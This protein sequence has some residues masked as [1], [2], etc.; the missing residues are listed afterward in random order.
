ME[1]NRV[2]PTHTTSAA[3]LTVRDILTVRDMGVYTQIRRDWHNP[4]SPVCLVGV[5]SASDCTCD[6]MFDFMCAWFGATHT[7]TPAITRVSKQVSLTDQDTN[8]EVRISARDALSAHTPFTH[9]R[10]CTHESDQHHID[11]RGWV[12]KPKPMQ[13]CR[14]DAVCEQLEETR[15]LEQYYTQRPPKIHPIIASA[16]NFFRHTE[17]SFRSPLRLRA[18]VS[19][20]RP[21][22]DIKSHLSVYLKTTLFA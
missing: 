9:M 18:Q 10:I 16:T 13:R 2:H 4:Q 21:D 5:A 19:G 22:R 6:C 11:E 15:T 20:E 12:L 8:E 3:V 7:I 1:R 17:L 14:R